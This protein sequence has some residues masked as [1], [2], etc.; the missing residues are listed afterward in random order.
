MDRD[1]E[2]PRLL[3][4]TDGVL[5]LEG[6]AKASREWNELVLAR[7]DSAWTE[8]AY[9]RRG[10]HRD[11][12]RLAVEYLVE[13]REYRWIA[14]NEPDTDFVCGSK[15]K[16]PHCITAP[17]HWHVELFRDRPGDLESFEDSF[18]AS[19]RAR[20]MSPRDLSLLHQLFGN[21]LFGRTLGGHVFLTGVDSR[22]KKAAL[23]LLRKFANWLSPCLKV[24]PVYVQP[25]MPLDLVALPEPSIIVG[26]RSG[27]MSDEARLWATCSIS[28]ACISMPILNEQT[29]DIVDTV[30][31]R[32][33][34]MVVVA[35]RHK[36]QDGG[37]DF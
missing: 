2:G 30:D 15:V 7:L 4:F 12:A 1:P 24:P 5:V 31:L 9:G 17:P 14:R 23:L 3:Y 32:H 25:S 8:Q 20:G 26:R 35:A 37:G 29:T 22:P 19:M 16:R 34:L 11:V 18:T 10:E 6:A 28:L 36:T 33:L 13:T 27:M 21:L